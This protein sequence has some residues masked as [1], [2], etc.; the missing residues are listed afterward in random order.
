MVVL[1]WPHAVQQPPVLSTQEHSMSSLINPLQE[2]IESS[3]QGEKKRI[4]CGSKFRAARFCAL[5][6]VFLKHALTR[7]TVHV[8][9]NGEDPIIS[10]DWGGVRL[11]QLLHFLR[12]YRALSNK[13]RGLLFCR[14]CASVG[15]L[16]FS[17]DRSYRWW[18]SWKKICFVQKWQN[19][20]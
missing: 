14:L 13:E 16:L 10:C 4:L 5:P 20:T 6:N 18:K 8:D 11:Y 3:S 1:C 12:S 15:V 17:H 19:L 2:R 7:N 9:F